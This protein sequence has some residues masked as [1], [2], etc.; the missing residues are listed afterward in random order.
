MGLLIGTGVP[1]VTGLLARETVRLQRSQMVAGAN[2]A[3]LMAISSAR[4][5]VLCPST[6]G[7]SCLPSPEWH[8]GWMAFIDGNDDREKQPSEQLLFH[9]SQ[10]SD[11]VMIE[12]SN[13]RRRIVYQ[14][15]G[16]ARGSNL[17][18]TFCHEHPDAAPLAMVISNS[19]RAR[20]SNRR[21]GGGALSCDD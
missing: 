12:T 10:T 1:L 17:T 5:V 20:T 9:Q 14:P 2:N 4:N 15:D 8:A 18:M 19:G 3:R 16:M 13:A 11:G 6:D 21:P 7:A